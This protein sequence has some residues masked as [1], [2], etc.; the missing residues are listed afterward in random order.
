LT[1][2]TSKWRASFEN[3][4]NPATLIKYPNPFRRLAD[5]EKPAVCPKIRLFANRRL[6]PEMKKATN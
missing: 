1:D 3:I 2:V 4:V 6:Q 5:I